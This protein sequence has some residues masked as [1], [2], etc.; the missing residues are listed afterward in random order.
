MVEDQGRNVARMGV[1]IPDKATTFGG[2]EDDGPE[3]PEVL[4]RAAET[5]D[6]LV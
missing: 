5:Q 2:L 1:A 4:S 6:G 3:D